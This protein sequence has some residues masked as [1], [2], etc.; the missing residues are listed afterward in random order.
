MCR[1]YCGHGKVYYYA[2]D[3]FVV[4]F[5]I[6]EENLCSR[7]KSNH[8]SRQRCSYYVAIYIVVVREY[9]SDS[10]CA[11]YVLFIFLKKFL[12]SLF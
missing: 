1:F 3:A 7:R 2:L 10:F 9:H 6:L 11:F 8:K 5:V 12:Q 4:I